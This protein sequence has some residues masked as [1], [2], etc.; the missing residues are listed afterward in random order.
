[1]P[2]SSPDRDIEHLLR[3]LAPQVLGAVVRRF[4]EFAASEDAVQEALIAAAVQW[5]REG[6]P[7]SPRSWLIR[8]AQR[9]MIDHLRGEA[10]RRKLAA[11]VA[12]ET[13]AVVAPAT[14]SEPETDPDDI[15]VLLFMCCH[16][17][18]TPASAIAL[19]LRA[20]GGLTT[21]QIAKA[22][23]VPELT[24]VR[25]ISR[26][27]E[28][29]RTSAIP[30]R[31]P[32][33]DERAARLGSVLYTLYL[34]FNEGYTSSGPDL[35]RPDLS[36]EA[37]RLVRE[38]HKLLPGDGDVAGLLALMLLI[39]AR[40][41]ARSGPSGELIPLD[42]Q[43]R[44]LW[45]RQK[46]GE[47]IALASAALSMGPVGEYQLQA[48]IAAVH[49]EADRAEDT[50]WPQIRALYEILLGMT[51]SPVVA[52]NH[53]VATAMVDG[54]RAGLALLAPL[55]D[56][57]RLRT[58]HRL[59]AVRAHLLERAGEREAAVELYRSAA[60]KTASIPERRYLLMK[61]AGR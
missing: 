13:A 24:V 41:A 47:G 10:S 57:P 8:V 51:A 55:Q 38:V 15:L 30:F 53:A 49:D 54:P 9:R 7:D 22:F 39:D 50:D 33:A 16:P 23:L 34:V 27:K 5:R 26:A 3:A 29:I 56:D 36:N 31:V 18:L 44:S 37:I 12:E 1:M 58:S 60:S 59:D 48:T 42:E 4:H 35:Q 2:S 61:A 45:D 11:A 28:A 32:D 25:R 19:T 14:D 46:I 20:V 6:I 21:A 17:A 52:L 40:R 43:D